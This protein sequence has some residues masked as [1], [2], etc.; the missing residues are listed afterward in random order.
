MARIVVLGYGNPLRDDDGVGWRVAQAVAER[1]AERLVVRTG[2]QLV[3]EWAIDLQDADLAYFVD[4]SV[5]VQLP[6]LEHI[7]C[8]GRTTLSDSHDLGPAQL[9]AMTRRVYGRAPD[10]FILHLPAAN[11]EY[12]DV[13]SPLAADGVRRAVCLLNAAIG[14]LNP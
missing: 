5:E 3:P 4:A 7:P 13:L 2:Q 8:D 1:W 12:G 9:L 11:F 6:K 10:A 14:A